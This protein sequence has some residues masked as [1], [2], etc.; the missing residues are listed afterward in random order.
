MRKINIQKD[1]KSREKISMSLPAIVSYD[2]VDE[3][4]TTE[5]S[6]ESEKENK[7]G[8]SEGIQEPEVNQVTDQQDIP[9]K[10]G[11]KAKTDL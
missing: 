8:Q 7:D 2:M 6:N 5:L 4:K 10:G 11:R 9:K 1:V 3:I